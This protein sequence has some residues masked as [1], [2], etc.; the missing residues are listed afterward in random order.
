MNFVVYVE[1][2]RNGIKLYTAPDAHKIPFDE[3]GRDSIGGVETLWDSGI[4]PISDFVWLV[5]IIKSV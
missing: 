4:I 5:L 1:S 2:V 3:F